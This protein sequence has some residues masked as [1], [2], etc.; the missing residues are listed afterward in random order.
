MIKINLYDPETD[1]TKHYEQNRISFGELKQILKFNKVQQ[2]DAAELKILNTKMDNGKLL[3]GAEEKKFVELSGKEDVYLNAL[4]ELVA[5]LFKSPK[6]TVQS[7][8]DGLSADG[9]TTL[10]DILAD[11]MGGIESDANHPSK[12]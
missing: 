2:E 6:V 3:T 4:E 7:I 9:M 12:K 5:K 10:K 1:E 11:A 8:D